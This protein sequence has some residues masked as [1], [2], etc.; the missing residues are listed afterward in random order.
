[1]FLLFLCCS[2]RQHAV[3][4]RSLTTCAVN[5]SGRSSGTIRVNVGEK[6]KTTVFKMLSCV[7]ETFVSIDCNLASK[8][9]ELVQLESANHLFLQHLSICFL[10]WQRSLFGIVSVRQSVLECQHY[11]LWGHLIAFTK[12]SKWSYSKCWMVRQSSLWN[13]PDTVYSSWHSVFLFW[14]RNILT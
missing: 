9:W 10:D 12:R 14:G 2:E 8:L 3:L 7:L 5:W 1:M 6:H 13:Y 4:I 11:L